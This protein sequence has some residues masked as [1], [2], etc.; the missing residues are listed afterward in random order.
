MASESRS[1][2][3][4]TAPVTMFAHLIV[5]AVATLLLVWLL[6][7]QEGF[8]FKSH[9]KLKIFDLHPLFMI[10]GFILIGGEAMMAYKTIPA[11]KIAQKTVHLLLNLVALLAGIVGIYAVFKYHHESGIP[12]LYSLHS[13]LGIGTIC[14]FGLQ[15]LL[16]F[17]SFVFPGAEMS[18]RAS[19]LPWH[20][21]FGPVF[22]LMAVCTAEAGLVQRLLLLRIFQGQEA[23]I[24]NFI[25]ILLILYTVSVGL[26]VVL[27]RAH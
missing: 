22:F 25:G 9:N 2:Q 3:I 10:I 20:R 21:F 14:L 15:W 19:F 27:P 4:S 11:T 8:A 24:V 17:L 1:L 6:A 12:D 5:T 13:W 18:R 16:G 7:K 26:T 23:L